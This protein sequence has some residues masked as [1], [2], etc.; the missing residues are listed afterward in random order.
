MNKRAP[1]SKSSEHIASFSYINS[2]KEE[3]LVLCS[4]WKEKVVARF[5]DSFSPDEQEAFDK[6]V[7]S[8]EACKSFLADYESMSKI[9]RLSSIPEPP[10]GLPSRLL[11]LWKDEDQQKTITVGRPLAPAVPLKG[12]YR[13]GDSTKGDSF[14][15]EISQ[16]KAI[17]ISFY[18]TIRHSRFWWDGQNGPGTGSSRLAHTDGDVPGSLL[19]LL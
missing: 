4:A 10:V 11:Q 8:C 7:S 9:L 12:S 16:E 5:P 1:F 17:P 6:H 14:G 13:G 15:S 3:E 19:C 2:K 18:K